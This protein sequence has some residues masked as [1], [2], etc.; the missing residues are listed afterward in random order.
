M[1][2]TFSKTAKRAAIY[3]RVST[4]DQDCA[5]QERDLV[6]YATRQGYEVLY[7][8][9]ETA[10]GTRD[11][12]KAR[13][14]LLA[15]A[16]AGHIDLILVT[17][18]TRWGRSTSD[19]LDTVRKL[20]SHKVSLIAQTGMTFDLSTPQGRLMLT[21][22]AGFSEFERD[23]IAERT[24]SGL[25]HAKAQGKQLGRPQGS[26]KTMKQHR[27]AVLTLREQGFSLQAIASKL[28]IGKQTVF[29]IVNSVQ[30]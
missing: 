17:E 18:L 20:A 11:D 12:R 5:R 14:K 10:S 27:K 22:M 4:Q 30:S 8:E 29:N 15:H 3:C 9:K 23:L 7:I 1:Q 2:D 16:Q 24:R 13:A 19:L 28:K 26:G 25:E 21:L 6:E